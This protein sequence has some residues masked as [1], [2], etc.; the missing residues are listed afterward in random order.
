MMCV[1]LANTE[2]RLAFGVKRCHD[3]TIIFKFFVAV[4]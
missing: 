1:L 2:R 4:A 3:N